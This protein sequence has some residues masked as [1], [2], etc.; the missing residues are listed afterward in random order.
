MQFEDLKKYK[1]ILASKS[2]RRQYLLKELGLQFDIHTK[3]VDE[4]FPD[5]LKAQQIPVYLAEKKANAFETELTSNTIVITSDTIV[6]VE[7]QVLNKPVDKADA[8]RMLQL[9]SGKKHEVYTGVCLKSKNKMHSF[10][11]CTQVYFK[12]LTLPE[13][14]YYVTNYSPYDKAG[15]YGAQE[16]IGYIAVEKIEGSY[17]NVMGLPLKELYEAL[18]KF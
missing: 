15:A 16:W 10:Y 6:W 4:S 9:L 2:P 8:I 14:E 13:I 12:T 3:D 11:A 18:L 1:F 17:F 7:N 5:N